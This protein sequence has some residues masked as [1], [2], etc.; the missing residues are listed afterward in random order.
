MEAQRCGEA[1]SRVG[2][3]LAHSRTLSQQII[4]IF[5]MER[6]HMVHGMFTPRHKS[7]LYIL[8]CSVV[9]LWLGGVCGCATEQLVLIPLHHSL[10]G[11][12][13][14]PSVL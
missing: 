12:H 7:T 3:R 10:L 2:A 8:N 9:L 4:T 14:T 11:T 13:C 6:V 5:L 1:K